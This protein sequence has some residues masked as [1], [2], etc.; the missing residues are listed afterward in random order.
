MQAYVIHLARSE[1]RLEGIQKRIPDRFV[2]WRFFDAIACPGNGPRG[3][4]LSHLGVI[5]AAKKRRLERVLILEDDVILKPNF[6]IPEHLP[7]PVIA[8]SASGGDFSEWKPLASGFMK[9]AD[10]FSCTAAMVV[11]CSAYDDLL[12]IGQAALSEMTAPEADIDLYSRYSREGG[13]VA[14]A[15][16]FQCSVMETPSTICAAKDA[17]NDAYILEAN[18]LALALVEVSAM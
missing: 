4:F 5:A 17:E 1:E 2:R 7:A 15:V 10:F 11:H 8:L 16:P 6:Y 12:R 14:M 13:A 9:V 3:C 18:E